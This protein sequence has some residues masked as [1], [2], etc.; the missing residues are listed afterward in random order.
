[1]SERID[2]SVPIEVV[3]SVIWSNDNF[4][5]TIVI[6]IVNESAF[7]YRNEVCVL[8]SHDRSATED[9]IPEFSALTFEAEFELVVSDASRSN[10]AAIAQNN[11]SLANIW[12]GANSQCAQARDKAKCGVP[13]VT[14]IFR[15]DRKPDLHILHPLRPAND[16]PLL[17]SSSCVQE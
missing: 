9:L 14:L 13:Y 5:K 2:S 10:N 3:P 15:T 6:E 4:R 12:I 16:T 8:P 17:R 11:F 1:M 7:H